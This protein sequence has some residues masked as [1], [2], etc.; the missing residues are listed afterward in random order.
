MKDIPVPTAHDILSDQRRAELE[1]DW[2]NMLSHQLPALPPLT[3]FLE[4]LP[5]V[6][7][8]LDGGIEFEELPPRQYA[9]EEDQDW[10]PPATV[11]TWGA[12]VPLEAVRFAATNHLL[13]ELTYQGRNRLIEPYS[14]RRIRAGRLL[15]HAERA[16][17]AGHRTYAIDQVQAVRA[18]T[19]PY[20]P[21]MPIEFSSQGLLHAPFHPRSTGGVRLTRAARPAP[22]GPAYVY[23]CV[24]CGR[25]FEHTRRNAT[26]HR[27]ND[28]SGHPC[29]GRRGVYVRTR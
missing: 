27:H 13:V 17:N 14:L 1:A 12:G 26:L 29:R 28:V 19:T 5:A 16:D 4:E 8:W 9:A 15:L 20:R 25:Q 18:T 6:F 22:S 7:A 24:V 3:P 2:T 11:W 23:R 21:R 10:S